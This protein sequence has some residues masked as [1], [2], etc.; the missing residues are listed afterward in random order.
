MAVVEVTSVNE[1]YKERG[2]VYDREDLSGEAP[3]SVVAD[4][5]S[6]KESSL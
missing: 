6:V 1:G 2:K 5:L 4:E 3:G